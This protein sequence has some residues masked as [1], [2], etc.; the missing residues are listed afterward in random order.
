MVRRICIAI[1]L[2]LFPLMVHSDD[3]RRVNVSYQ[4]DVEIVDTA[5]PHITWE[6]SG[7]LRYKWENGRGRLLAGDIPAMTQRCPV[8]I[9]GYAVVMLRIHGTPGTEASVTFDSEK[10]TVSG[11]SLDLEVLEAISIAGVGVPPPRQARPMMHLTFPDLR[12]TTEKID[13]ETMSADLVFTTVIPRTGNEEL[14]R[15]LA[16]KTVK[17]RFHIAL[18][19]PYQK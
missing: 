8:A 9:P 17:G 10:A 16:G 12:M 7:P 15:A 5:Y 13:S 3:F 11:V 14:D 4:L 18:R 19:N 6:G 2:L 1:L